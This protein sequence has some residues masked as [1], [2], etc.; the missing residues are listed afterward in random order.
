[1]RDLVSLLHPIAAIAPQVATDNTAIV[2]AIIDMA[3]YDGAAFFISLG[4]VADADTTAAVTM[5]H[6]D[7]SNLSDTA[8]VAAADLIG[9]LALAGF[10]FADDNEIRKIGYRGSKRYVRFT[11]TPSGNTG[12]LPISAVAV[13]GHPNVAPTPNPP[14]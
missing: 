11:V 14:Q 6:G 9:T 3:G 12:N 7:A 13:L 5:E 1:M 8:A 4:T 2:S 10:T